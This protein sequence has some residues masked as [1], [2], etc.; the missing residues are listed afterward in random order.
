MFFKRPV[1][2]RPRIGSSRA[3]SEWI[4]RLRVTAAI[5]VDAEVARWARRKADDENTSASKLV[6]QMLE[7]GMR[8]NDEYWRAYER[9]K[10]PAPITEIDAGAK[11]TRDELHERR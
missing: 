4:V 7:R 10:Q 3:A 2:G 5:T 1:H 11:L 8:M 9:R 6:G